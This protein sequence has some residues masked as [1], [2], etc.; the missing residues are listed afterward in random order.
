MYRRYIIVG[1]VFLLL[2]GAYFVFFDKDKSDKEYSKYYNKLVDKEEYGDNLNGV[3]LTIFESE[4]NDKYSYV[5]TFDNVS[6]VNKNVKIL[7]AD[8]SKKDNK[9]YYPSFGIVDNKGYSIIPSNSEKKEKEVKGVNLTVVDV[10]KIEY[11]LVYYSSNDNEQ[12]VK[13]KVSNYLG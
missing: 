1:V 2:V 6:V 7:V 4:E 3:T 9:E 8:S 13:V 5:V 11:L 10:D 12:F